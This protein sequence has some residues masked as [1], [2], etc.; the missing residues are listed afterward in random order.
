M[1]T[2]VLVEGEGRCM[3]TAKVRFLQVQER[4]SG[5]LPVPWQEGVEREV[6]MGPFPIQ[7]LCVRWEFR[8]PGERRREESTE[9]RELVRETNDLAGLVVLRAEPVR[10]GLSRVALTL[11]NRTEPATSTDL[12]ETERRSLMAAHA[13]LRVESGRFVSLTDPPAAEAEPARACRNQGAWPVLIGDPT[14]VLCSPIILPDYP[15]LAEESP[16][17]LFDGTEIDEILSLR[18]RTLTEAEKRE[19]A[20]IDPRA[21]AILERTDALARRELASLHGAWRT[22]RETRHE[23]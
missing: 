19:M 22:E 11:L 14:T 5:A 9:G 10:P 8:I 23:P 1:H 4:I 17:D 7:G 15:R 3:L 18:I 6:G 16:G 21:R 20:S 12:R 2:E 13:I